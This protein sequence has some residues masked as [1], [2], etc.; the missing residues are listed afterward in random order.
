MQE[1]NNKSIFKEWLEKLQQESW[2]LELLI[3]GFAIFGIYAAR[4]VITDIEFMIHNDFDGDFQFLAILFYFILKTGWLIFFINLIVHVIL[5]GLWIGAI[6]LRYVSQDI[7]YDALRYSPRMTEYLKT[8]VGSY[9]DFI[10]RL[11]KICSVLFAFTFLLFMLFLSLMLFFIQIVLIIELG[12]IIFKGNY[13][14][15]AFVTYFALLYL[16]LGALVFI[17]LITLGGFKKI[18]EKS[19]SRIYFF[20]YRYFSATTL[21]FLYR[22]LLYN[23]IDNDYTRKLFYI[24]IPYIFV[25][26]GGY[27]MFE[28]VSNPYE[29]ARLQKLYSGTLLDDVYYDDLRNIRLSEYPNEER[30]VNKEQ[31]RWISLANFNVTESVSSLFIRI[32][33]DMVK[34]ASADTSLVPYK[35]SGFSFRWF[36][37]N[38]VDDKFLEATKKGKEQVIKSLYDKKREIKSKSKYSNQKSELDS[39]DA[40]IYQQQQY[41]NNKIQGTENAKVYNIIS[42][43]ANQI[44]LYVDTMKVDLRHCYYYTH[45]NYNEQ[46][47]KCF[48]ETDSISRG[49]H[50]LKIIK[51]IIYGNNDK[52]QNDSIILPIIKH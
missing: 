5:R 48:F 35:K 52:I 20:L 33:T 46:G 21:S 18:K 12:N 28:N 1:D 22:P 40:L 36:N 51:K 16:I 34:I 14:G 26:I 24:S 37:N 11:E 6:G 8:K 17:D 39:M 38:M 47:L 43:F 32:N 9:D 19:I 49:I 45:P 31:L 25:V 30:K 7:N 42:A 44:E 3:S 2:Q 27:T 50:D 10:E 23:F 41:W 13:S 15:V 29:P 4:T